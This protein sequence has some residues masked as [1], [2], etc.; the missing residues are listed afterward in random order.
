MFISQG[1]RMLEVDE[2]DHTHPRS[3][4]G[5]VVAENVGQGE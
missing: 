1:R 2:A 5:C 3:A 4:S